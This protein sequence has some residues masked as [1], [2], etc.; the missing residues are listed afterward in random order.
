MRV[1]PA[2]ESSSE[3]Q[4]ALEKLSRRRTTPVRVM[5]RS[6]IILLAAEG[7]QNKEMRSDWGLRHAWQRFGETVFATWA[8]KD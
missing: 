6:C 4:L 1:A 5:Q 3:A 8:W 7:M 2:I